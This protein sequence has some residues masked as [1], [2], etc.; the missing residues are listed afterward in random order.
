MKYVLVNKNRLIPQ[1][2]HFDT[3]KSA[4]NELIEMTNLCKKIEL[5]INIYIVCET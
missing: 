1:I 2:L 4:I 5:L 3:E